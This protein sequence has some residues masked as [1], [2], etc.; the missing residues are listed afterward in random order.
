MS[1]ITIRPIRLSD[2]EHIVK[3]RNSWEV[4]KNLYT[5]TELT[6]EQHKQWM[7]K[8]VDT[9]QCYQFIIEEHTSQDL[10]RDV[11]TVFI[12]NIDKNSNKGE[13]G[14]FIGEASARG[15][16]YAKVATK[17]ILFFAFNKLKL[18]RVY[19]SVFSDNLSAIKSYENAGFALEGELVQD[20]R[21]YDG[22]ANVTLMGIT[23]DRW[24]TINNV[25]DNS[26]S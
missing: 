16:G 19:L 14:I 12:K 3:W 7:K 21:R 22:Y 17:Q 15:R 4:Q 20:F 11:G 23:R 10:I 24:W 1:N 13:F 8:F 2:T 25:T 26:N 5:Q 6:A 9:H 18:N